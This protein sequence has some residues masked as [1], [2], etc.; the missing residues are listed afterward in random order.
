MNVTYIRP[1]NI[2]SD[3][4]ETV[5]FPSEWFLPLAYML[6]QEMIPEVDTPDQ[7]SAMIDKLADKYAASV[8]IF[9]LGKLQPIPEA[10]A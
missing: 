2:T 4:G 7:A 6:A 3:N 8:G 9:P 1:I 5:D 10:G